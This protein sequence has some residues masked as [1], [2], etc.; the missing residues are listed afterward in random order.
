MATKARI[1][2][3]TKYAAKTYKTFTLRIRK[4]TQAELIQKLESV[5]SANKYL[6]D[7]IKKDLK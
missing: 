6:C 1:R 5:D 7:L 2:A 3:N 4:D